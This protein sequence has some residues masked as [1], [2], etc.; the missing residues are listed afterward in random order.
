MSAIL[1]KMPPAIRSAAAPSDLANREADKAGA[2]VIG[3]D[4][5]KNEKHDQQFDRD[6]QH[7]DAHAGL[8]RNRI[9]RIRL[10]AQ[11]RE[12]RP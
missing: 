6:Q 1:V 9:D 8:Q 10:A 7:A 11:S 4:E 2:R 12:R 5:Q 3:R